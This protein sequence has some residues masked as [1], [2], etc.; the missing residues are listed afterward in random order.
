MACEKMICSCSLCPYCATT[1]CPHLHD[2]TQYK[3]WVYCVD[4]LRRVLPIILQTNSK[5][6]LLQKLESWRKKKVWAKKYR[7]AIRRDAECNSWKRVELD[8]VELII[9]NADC[10][11]TTAIR[12]RLDLATQTYW[13]SKTG[14]VWN[15][16]I[17]FRRK[18][19]TQYR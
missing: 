7:T 3:Y 19:T 15:G 13:N 12:L 6:L 8:Y 9:T 14:K 17:V 10:N 5:E 18:N 11:W 2:A 4:Q 1:Q 16:K